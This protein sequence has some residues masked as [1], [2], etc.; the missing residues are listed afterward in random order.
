MY[1]LLVKVSQFFFPRGR[2]TSYS[3]L[4]AKLFQIYIHVFFVFL[5]LL[6]VV[7]LIPHV[8]T[9]ASLLCSVTG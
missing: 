2:S 6:T 3:L 4:M 9:I 1:C 7:A 8:M 5:L